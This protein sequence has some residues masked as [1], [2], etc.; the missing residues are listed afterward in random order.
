MS[1]V[2]TCLKKYKADKEYGGVGEEV[3][4]LYMVVTDSL[5]EYCRHREQVLRWDRA[6]H[7]GG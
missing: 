2:E 5:T 1:D 7:V 4:P 3:V 6:W